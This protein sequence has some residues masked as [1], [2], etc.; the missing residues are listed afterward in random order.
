M[1]PGDRSINMKPI[2]LPLIL[3]L[4]S[5][6]CDAKEPDYSIMQTYAE[7][8]NCTPLW[9]NSNIGYSKSHWSADI[10]SLLGREGD[11]VFMCERKDEYGFNTVFMVVIISETNRK[12]WKSCPSHIDITNV[13]PYPSGLAITKPDDSN[14]FHLELSN[15]RDEGG[16]PGPKGII[17]TEPVIDTSDKTAGELFY[18]YEGKWLSLLVD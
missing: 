5:S 11:V 12:I 18:C 2:L 9:E 14:Y 6:I 4:L 7:N 10:S 15:W 8:V 1:K 13:V 3:L 16:N 17:P